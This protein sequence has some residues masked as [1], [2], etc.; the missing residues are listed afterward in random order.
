M[1]GLISDIRSNRAVCS[2]QLDSL[3]GAAAAVQLDESSRAFYRDALSR[4]ERE[5]V[6]YLVGGAYAFARYTG[7]ERHTK[8]FDI[9][10][11]REDFARAAE[12]LEKAGYETELTFSHWLGKAFHGDDFVDLIFSAGNGVATV[13]DLWFE[14]AVPAQVIGMD[15]QLIPPAKISI[16][17]VS[18]IATIVTG[19]CSTRTA[20]SS[21]SSIHR[22]DQTFRSGS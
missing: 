13:D 6:K 10:I 2:V 18:S 12:T 20:S 17:G 1:H 7:I 8:D 14:H 19:A 11:R 22:S 9:F 4:L 15:V 16:G 5:G 3:M 21:A